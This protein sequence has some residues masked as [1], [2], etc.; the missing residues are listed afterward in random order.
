MKEDPHAADR[1]TE[2]YE[3]EVKAIKTADQIDNLAR[4]IAYNPE[5]TKHTENLVA[6]GNST[7]RK[8]LDASEK[9]RA[10]IPTSKVPLPKF[11]MRSAPLPKEIMRGS[12]VLGHSRSEEELALDAE[13]GASLGVLDRTQAGMPHQAYRVLVMREALKLSKSPTTKQYAAAK[14]MVDR[15][16]ANKGIGIIIPAARPG[17]V[18]R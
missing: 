13:C 18:T 11:A 17:R 12:A 7:A 16:L 1:R 5:F 6:R 15:D 10:G 2:E 9:Y 14:A 3:A 8:I 4:M